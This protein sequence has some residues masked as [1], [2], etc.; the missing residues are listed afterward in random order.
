M[1][2]KQFVI[3]VCLPFHVINTQIIQ[4]LCPVLNIT[5]PVNMSTKMVATLFQGDQVQLKAFYKSRLSQKKI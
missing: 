1:F 4:K 5:S 3:L 2:K